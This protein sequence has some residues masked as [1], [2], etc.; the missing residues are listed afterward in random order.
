MMKRLVAT[1][2]CVMIV[3]V[4]MSIAYASVCS[5]KNVDV[6]M[7]WKDLLV[8]AEGH[9]YVTYQNVYCHDCEKLILDYLRSS[10][11]E[12][13]DYLAPEL[14]HDHVNNK[15]FVIYR[16][17]VCNY[18]AIREVDCSG[19]PCKIIYWSLRP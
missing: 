4:T 18:E 2:L 11:L 13:H 1:L 5:H 16:C 10:H 8:T 15:D 9:E 17:S 12:A 3:C 14:E 6:H 19:P 7:E